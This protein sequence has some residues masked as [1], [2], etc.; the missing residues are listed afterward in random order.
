MTVQQYFGQQLMALWSTFW[1]TTYGASENFL[2]NYLWR[3]RVLFGQLLMA[4]LVVLLLFQIGYPILTVV[5]PAFHWHVRLISCITLIM[6]RYADFGKSS[7]F[8]AAPSLTPMHRGFKGV[9][10]F[11]GRGLA[12][13]WAP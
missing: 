12:P 10:P 11:Q 8:L 5:H 4:D 6:P 3:F 2:A 9:S 13:P 1:P 7:H